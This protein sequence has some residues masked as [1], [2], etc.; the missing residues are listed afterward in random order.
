MKIKGLFGTLQA[1]LIAALLIIG[2][3]ASALP[4][5]AASTIP[6]TSNPIRIM[7]GVPTPT[8]TPPSSN[9]PIDCSVG[10]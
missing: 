4:S 6:S 10:C 2:I 7:D 9:G 8:P 1:I 3:V 5:M